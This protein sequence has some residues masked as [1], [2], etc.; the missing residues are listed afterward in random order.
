MKKIIVPLLLSALMVVSACARPSYG[1][2]LRSD[3]P[4][5]SPNVPAADMAELVRG[6]T[7]FA[8]ALY[9][10]LKENDGNFFYSPHS[11]STALTMTWGGARGET[12]R[13]MAE[14]LRFTLEQQRLHD[15]LNA[16]DAALASRG[17]DAK[18]KNGEPF[19][20]KEVNAIWGQQ[21]YQFL[22]AY[23]DLLAESYGAGLRIVD[24][25]ND[26]EGARKAINDWVAKETGER[27]K[28]LLPQGSIDELTR[29][30]LTNAIYFSGAW[31]NP[32]PKDATRDDTFTLINGNKITV[33]MMFQSSTASYAEGIIPFSSFFPS[34]YQA[35]ELMYDGGELSMV[36]L[37]PEEGGFNAFENSLSVEALEW[38]MDDLNAATVNLTMPKFEFDSE[39]GLKESLSALG[40]P[41]AFTDDA[42]FSGMNG[43]RDLLI[44]DVVHKA[45]VSVDEAGTEAAAATGVVVGI[46]SAPVDP[47]TVTIDRPFI[48]LIRD[49]ATGAVLFIGRVMNPLE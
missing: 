43:Q 26:P 46:T 8:M 35:V 49:V 5:L 28:D 7:E 39:F 24:Y 25:I 45:F 31:L 32:F 36:V 1:E 34:G 27:I 23:L 6:N 22:T 18:G 48:F 2:E 41:I 10:L 9:H 11:I 30:V 29:L 4:R 37:L 33:P 15:A 20:L 44:S 19:S 16:L 3:K 42:D 14:A 38:I 40:M 47:A 21:D 17:Q 13:Q 12:E